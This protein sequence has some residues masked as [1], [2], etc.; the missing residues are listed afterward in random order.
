MDILRYD[1]L[2]KVLFWLNSSTAAVA[3]VAAAR[4][5]ANPPPPA[6]PAG[7]PNMMP[8]QQINEY[9]RVPDKMVGLSKVLYLSTQCDNKASYFL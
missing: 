9:I 1:G 3:A 6:P 4:M 2:Y 8:D 5:A 7:P